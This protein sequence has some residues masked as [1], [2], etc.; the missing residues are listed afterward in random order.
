MSGQ[1]LSSG[2]TTRRRVLFGLLDA[3]GWSWAS[4]KAFFWFIVIIFMLGYIPDRAYYF[5]VFSTIDL[6]ILAWSPVN[7]CPPENRTLPCPVPAGAVLPWEPSPPELA[8]PAARRDG[9]AVV[10]GTKLLYIGGT[11]GT[12]ASDKV[13]VATL[14]PNGNFS[15]WTEG[16]ALPQPLTDE[17]AAFLG[18]QVFVFGGS[19]A[20]GAPTTSAYVTTVDPATGTLGP[21]QTADEAK[22]PLA[23]PAPRTG[24]AIAVAGDGLFLVGGNDGTGPVSSVWKSTLDAKGKLTAWQPQADLV[25]PQSDA[26]AALI[27]DFLWVYGGRDANGPTGAVQRGELGTVDNHPGTIVRF[28]VRNGPPNLPVARTDAATFTVNGAI[29]LIGGFDGTAPRGELYWAIPSTNGELPEW[30]HLPQTDL[31]VAGLAGS[32]AVTSGSEAFL[33]GGATAGGVI[34]QSV[35]ANL[36]PQPPFFQLGLVGATI[37]ALKISGEIGQQLGYLS[38]AG[39]GTINFVILLLIGWA[40]AHKEQ[41]RGILG[42]LRRRGGRS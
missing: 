9:A 21:W 13:F 5:T 32:A 35:R 15:S 37:P 18:G 14:Y 19:D 41:A 17:A 11:D 29:Y 39:V 26:G 33:I 1:A 38:A 10:A 40:F 8:L 42:R 6:G 24:A 27:G 20:S 23:L 2:T 4:L 7:L 36:A 25:R 28:G 31:P 3:D 16:P 22:L 12:A 34:S 30:Q